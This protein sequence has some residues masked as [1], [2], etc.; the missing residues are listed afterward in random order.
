M[1]KYF[2]NLAID[3]PSGSGGTAPRGRTTSI[4]HVK[5]GIVVAILVIGLCL[6]PYSTVVGARQQS[7]VKLVTTP[8]CSAPGS[9][10]RSDVENERSISVQSPFEEVKQITAGELKEL[11]KT[12]NVEIVDVRSR[13]K[14]KAGRIKGARLLPV[15]EI[16]TRASE[17][18]GEKLIITYCSCPKE[19]SAVFAALELERLGFKR[20]AVLRGG[21]RA[22]EEAGIPT[23]KGEPG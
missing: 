22:A 8:V 14:W 6:V 4:S 19:S 11:L 17:L 3:R 2:E 21:Y 5:P 10:A 15:N 12:G 18:N 23:E 7:Q 9:P 13:E 16:T 20:V 1:A